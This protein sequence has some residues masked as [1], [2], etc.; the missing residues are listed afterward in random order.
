MG[1][2]TTINDVLLDLEGSDTD[3][4]VSGKEIGR[5]FGKVTNLMYMNGLLTL[6]SEEGT[7]YIETKYISVVTVLPKRNETM[8]QPTKK[9]WWKIW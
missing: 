7:K 1:N 9:P 5:Y 6:K 4:Y 3:I 8:E 2:P